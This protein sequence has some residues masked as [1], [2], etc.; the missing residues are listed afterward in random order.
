M[1]YNEI[2]NILRNDKK[3]VIVVFG[4]FSLDKYLLIDGDKDELSLETDL[5]AYQVV[6]RQLYPGA[7]GT[8]ANNLLAMGANVSCVGIVGDDGEGYEL[9]EELKKRGADTSHM[10]RTN[11]RFTNTYVKPMYH[12]DKKAK[13][14]NR[15]DIKNFSKTPMHLQESLLNNLK[16]IL[17]SVDAVIIS[18][19]FTEK[20]CAA[21]TGFVQDGLSKLAEKFS[22]I[23]WYADSRVNINKFKNIILKCNHK[24]IAQVFGLDEE[25]INES[26]ALKYAEKLYIEGG[27]PVFVTLGENGSV[28][29]DGNGYKIPAFTVDG[30][31]DVVGAGDACNAGIVFSL[32]K[33]A[34]LL[35]AGY[36]GNASSSVTIKKIGQTGTAN[37]D[38]IADVLQ[39][40]L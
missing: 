12:K 40:H 22:D 36:T 20:D 14:L 27:K 16:E 35:Q 29:F 15:L 24:E 21:V 10:V 30:E 26:E 25:N 19:Q 8:I 13:E 38:E 4:D 39:R 17:P 18:D 5:I 9:L 7:G 32:A 3:P 34:S 11:E 37:V 1:D 6:G 33:G 2:I 28:L 31:I 23:I